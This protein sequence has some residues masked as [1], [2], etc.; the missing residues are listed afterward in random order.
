MLA[1][2]LTVTSV[3]RAVVEHID[4]VWP[5]FE[6]AGTDRE[7]HTICIAPIFG[8]LKVSGTRAVTALTSVLLLI[9]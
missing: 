7:P 6:V 8:F 1:T 5:P 3:L 9:Q 2:R 4:D